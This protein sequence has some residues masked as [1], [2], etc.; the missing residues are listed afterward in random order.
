MSIID[1]MSI[2][3]RISIFDRIIILCIFGSCII[4]YTLFFSCIKEGFE[5]TNTNDTNDTNENK[6][7]YKKFSVFY[8]TFLDTWEK[9][10]VTSIGLDKPQEASQESPKK[11]ISSLKPDT[12]TRTE[13]NQYINKLSKTLG[14]LPPLTDPLPERTDFKDVSTIMPLIPKDPKPFQNALDWV[15]S[16]IEESHE[17][18]KS[19]LKG[20]HFMNFD[21]NFESFTTQFDT[22]EKFVEND[23][24][25][26]CQ[27]I[28]NCPQVEKCMKQKQMVDKKTF[29]TLLD[30]FLTNE[31]L[32]KA[33]E[34]NE[35]L[36][37]ESKKIENQAK[38][39]DLL[40]KLDLPSDTV[41]YE[42][43]KG[44]DKLSKMKNSDPEKY[45]KLKSDSG[46]LFDLKQ[47][48]EQINST[49]H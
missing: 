1:R 22:L 9:T 45:K 39:G 8:N 16:K 10:I 7:K 6:E 46:S 34:K 20:E 26:T 5:D 18:L 36:M 41:T 12:P 32:M 29:F 4:M 44:S 2:L 42:L 30:T 35:T 19:S 28:A 43:P 13:I 48:F 49:L 24:N 11:P 37:A 23:T 21:M 14:P 25:D 31:P 3:N 38:S 27:K 17:K 47:M 33:S 40:S 15:N